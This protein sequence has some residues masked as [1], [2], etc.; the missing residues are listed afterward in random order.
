MVT[1]FSSLLAKLG[2]F[3]FQAVNTTGE[4]SIHLH[5]HTHTHTHT[6]THTHT[7][8]HT[9]THTCTHTHAHTHTHTHTH[10][11][12]STHART[13]ARAH[14]HAHTH[15]HTHTSYQSHLVTVNVLN[16][17][18]HVWWNGLVRGGSARDTVECKYIILRLQPPNQ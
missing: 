5:T 18:Q 13:H 11:P 14:I 10:H 4:P 1:Q 15:T 7:H 9:R 3:C 17:T 2:S 16:S 12:T 8:I 6:R